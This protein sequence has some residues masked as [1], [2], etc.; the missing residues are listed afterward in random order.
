MSYLDEVNKKMKKSRL[1]NQ[2]TQRVAALR[3]KQSST[4]HPV[5]ADPP[6]SRMPID[7]DENRRKPFR[8]REILNFAPG[9]KLLKNGADRAKKRKG[10]IRTAIRAG[11]DGTSAQ[12][13]TNTNKNSPRY[14][15][16]YKVKKAKGGSWH[17]YD[18]GFRVFVKSGTKYGA[19]PKRGQTGGTYKFLRSNSA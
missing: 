9:E 18:N 8:D 6:L 17:T 16:A 2:E 3:D 12:R 13:L 11:T 7:A 4:K 14:G 5:Y 15:Q 1:S 10:Q 19:T